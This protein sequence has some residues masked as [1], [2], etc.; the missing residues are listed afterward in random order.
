MNDA[1][2]CT[3]HEAFEVKRVADK[4]VTLIKDGSKSS[5]RIVQEFFE[6]KNWYGGRESAEYQQPRRCWRHARY[7]QGA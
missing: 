4:L 5:R 3:Q 2:Q 6:V 7:V 1:C